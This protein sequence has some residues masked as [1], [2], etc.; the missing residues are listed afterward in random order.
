[1]CIILSVILAEEGE[2]P[3]PGSPQHP[4]ELLLCAELIPLIRSLPV[5]HMLPDLLVEL[6]PQ[7]RGVDE[8]RQ[9]GG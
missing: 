3:V 1:M 8:E 5:T 6:R 4:V 2:Q 7:E 9:D